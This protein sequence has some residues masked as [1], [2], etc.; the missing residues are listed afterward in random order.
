[1]DKTDSSTGHV[2]GTP[3]SPNDETPIPT[4]DQ[5]DSSMGLVRETPHPPNDQ[6]DSSTGR[7][8]ETPHRPKKT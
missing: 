3:H 2:I 1:M 6:T 8:R 7:V 5:T 4:Y